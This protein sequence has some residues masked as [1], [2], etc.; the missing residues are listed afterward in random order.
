LSEAFFIRL[1][2]VLGAAGDPMPSQ[3]G[4][5]VGHLIESYDLCQPPI[6]CEICPSNPL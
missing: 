2:L 5:L 1:L 4:R 6:G 3:A